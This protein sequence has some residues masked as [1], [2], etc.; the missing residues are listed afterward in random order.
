MTRVCVLVGEGKSEKAFLSSLLTHQHRFQP[1]TP[2]NNIAYASSSDDQLFWIFPVPS[3]GQ[4]H[5]GGRH[6][7][8]KER[9]YIEAQAK[10]L[11]HVWLL[12]D[13]PELHYRILTDTDSDN[14]AMLLDREARIREAVRISGITY[15][16]LKVAYSRREIEAWYIAG[17]SNT[18]FRLDMF[19][20]KKI[21]SRLLNCMPEDLVDPK[22]DLDD[23]LD[24]SISG[25]RIRIGSDVGEY[26]DVES[27]K[28]RAPSFKNFI[29]TLY[30]DNLL[31]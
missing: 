18:T 5:R 12:G 24:I 3:Y 11:G 22:T 6:E 28:G 19:K 16:S 9:V 21:L 14:D 8:E 1:S 29:E 2:K 20:D 10:V 31:I 15:S 7:L 17:L 27:A 4:T 26:I 13:R 23:A 25:D 30:L